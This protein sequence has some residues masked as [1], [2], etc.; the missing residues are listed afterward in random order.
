MAS[1]STVKADS[2][3][4]KF[5]SISKDG[6]YSIRII[7]DQVEE[8]NKF[9]LTVDGKLRSMN[10]DK[11]GR[12]AAVARSGGCEKSSRKFATL[13]YSEDD[14]RVGILEIGPQIL[15]QMQAVMSNPKLKVNDITKVTFT[16]TVRATS[17]PKYSVQLQEKHTTAFDASA[18]DVPDFAA[19]CEPTTDAQLDMIGVP[20]ATAPA[21][22][23][24]AAA[25]KA[26]ST[27]EEP[28]FSF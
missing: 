13:A 26:K 1:F 11:N 28:D 14:D 9:W 16:I 20:Q 21:N 19:H 18:Y 27:A 23:A 25:K 12:L 2:G 4:G 5:L 7:R 6:V 3:S 15:G 22:P 17:K 8:L 24:P 10:E